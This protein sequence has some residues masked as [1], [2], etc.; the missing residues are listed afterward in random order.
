MNLSVGSVIRGK[1]RIDKILGQGG[2]GVV[3]GA[4]HLALDQKVAIKFLLP[5]MLQHRA[6]VERFA[7]E[8]RAAS[9][10]QSD[11]VGRVMDVDALEDG[12][13]FIVM[14]YL[15][16]H[17]L[18]RVRKSGQVLAVHVAVGY[19]LEACEAVAEAHRAGIVHRDLKPAN[20]FLSQRLDGRTR[21][22][23]L[24]FGISKLGGDA[25]EAS[26]TS[27]SAVMG[28][29]EYMAPEQ[30][31]STKS[32]DA[33][34]DIW[35]LGVCLYE[36]LTAR[37]PFPGES[38]T[39]VCALVLQTQ[40]RAPSEL[41]T[42]VPHGLNLIVMRCLEKNPAGRFATVEALVTALRPFSDP[43]FVE[44]N[45]GVSG[46]P[47]TDRIPGGSQP[48]P[49]ALGF[50]AAPRGSSADG[51]SPKAMTTGPELSTAILAGGPQQSTSSP[52]FG[53]DP[54]FRSDPAL[55]Q[56]TSYSPGSGGQPSQ[57]SA[58]TQGAFS[59]SS[60]QLP[61]RRSRAGILAIGALVSLLGVGTAVY[62]MTRDR[63]PV[64]AGAS[65][66]VSPADTATSRAAASLPT[67]PATGMPEMTSVAS[68]PPM[69]TASSTGVAVATPMQSADLKPAVGSPAA[70][71]PGTDTPT[72]KP[73]SAK[74]CNPPFTVD[75]NGIKHA[76]PECL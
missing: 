21:V 33:R 43:A 19:L 29:A 31:L 25:S 14:E 26:V 54:A 67:T 64:N 55:A 47:T 16:G 11:H 23:V 3:V 71:K 10:I 5:A 52:T 56:G 68:A 6:I 24:D 74:S 13:P 27:T 30:M 28:S 44:A 59:S 35:A 62:V 38:L 76:K 8:A 49:T 58:G 57:S 66:G 61:Q 34:S 53:S 40:P 22:K 32:A 2:M 60:S 12:S 1:Y 46:Q 75:A 7:R 69:A 65:G 9:K 39:Q 17:D 18:S 45:R 41:R 42:E 15:E 48:P 72:P 70:A 73:A 63:E 4:H 36:L 20:L 37:V 50:G 51:L